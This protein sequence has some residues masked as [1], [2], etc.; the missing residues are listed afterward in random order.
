MNNLL[1]GMVTAL[2]FGVAVLSGLLLML[3]VAWAVVAI[4]RMVV[5]G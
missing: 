1:D 3:I 5:G 4:T 2:G